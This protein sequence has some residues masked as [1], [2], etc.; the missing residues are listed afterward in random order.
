M[1]WTLPPSFSSDRGLSDGGSRMR[2]VVPSPIRDSISA[3]PPDWA[4]KPWIWARPR[5]VPLPI[6]LVVK[7]GSNA[8]LTTSSGMP[9]PVSDT[10][11]QIYSCPPRLT[12]PVLSFRTARPPASHRA[13]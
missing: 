7:N 10:A 5:P 12:L 6:S 3:S 8:R 9:S 13:H 2:R 4:A 11:T 1:A